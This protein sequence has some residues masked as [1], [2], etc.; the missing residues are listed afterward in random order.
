MS[1]IGV[2]MNLHQNHGS[3][4]TQDLVYDSSKVPEQLE[5]LPYT[6]KL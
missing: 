3:Q 2:Q 5:V 6:P 1:S 4:E